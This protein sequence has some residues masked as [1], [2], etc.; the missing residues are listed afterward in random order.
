MCAKY[1]FF[2]TGDIDVPHTNKIVHVCVNGHIS[3]EKEQHRRHI[4]G[5]VR[6]ALTNELQKRSA[7][8]VKLQMLSNA[9]EEILQAGNLNKTVSLDILHKISKFALIPLSIILFSEKQIRCLASD[10]LR[11][12]HLDATGSIIAHPKLLSTASTIYYY[13]LVLPGNIDVGPLSVAEFISSKHDITAIKHFLDVFNDKF[14]KI[15]T[16]KIKKIETDFF[17]RK[18]VKR[19]NEIKNVDD[20][21]ERGT[22]QSTTK[23][24]DKAIVKIFEK[25]PGCSLRRAKNLL[26][27]KGIDVSLNTIRQ[28]L[29]D[30]EYGW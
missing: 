13:A 23:K 18:W 26:L 5:K 21:P 8:V 30:S 29:L 17:V 6:A 27:K 14:K 19:Y 9:D 7:I 25:N 3:H 28:R 2:V 4:R 22:Q 20:L 1:K 11:H 24:D 16:K 12:L 10:K 15:T